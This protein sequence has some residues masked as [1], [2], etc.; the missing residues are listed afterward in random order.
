MALAVKNATEATSQSPFDRLAIGSL[1]GLAYVLGGIALV[2]YLIPW[3][4]E[5]L[6][7]G[8]REI[9]N[10][11]VTGTLMIVLMLAAAIAVGYLG[12]RLVGFDPPHGFRAGIFTAA[13]GLTSICFCT[14]IVG[15]IL[16]AILTQG[17]HAIGAIVTAA[18]G[19][20]LVFLAVRRFLR[21]DTED[22]LITIEDQGWFSMA[23]YKKSQGQ[24]VRRGTMLGI[25]ALAG[26]GIY[27]L[28][29]HKTLVYG[30][31]GDNNFNYWYVYI[32]F[33]G[34]DPVPLLRDVRFTIPLLL[35]AA[36]LWFAYRVVNF[37]TFADFLIATEAE[38]NKVSWTSR[39]R[40]VQDTI[41]VLTT[42]VL[43]TIFLFVI[44]ILWG[45]LL[46]RVGVLQSDSGENQPKSG[47]QAQPW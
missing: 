7:A 23:G 37:P 1:T 33:S 42:V 44:D 17:T 43:M 2:F 18:C 30:L 20:A 25:L 16:E 3:V 4:W 24:R 9:I 31:E 32:P 10:A 38:L 13:A 21:P 40:L 39:K 14:W 26:C 41:V 47:Q 36:S 28:I 34:L 11:F 29:S 12:M 19:I 22:L 5:S 15:R 35:A 45:F 6:F 8:D 46:S 27:T